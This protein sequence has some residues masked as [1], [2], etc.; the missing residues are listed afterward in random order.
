MNLVK[1]RRLHLTVYLDQPLTGVV[2]AFIE[3]A[4]A[5]FGLEPAETMK[6]TLAGEEIFSFL[7]GLAR[8]DETLEIGCLGRG[9]QVELDFLLGRRRFNMKSFNLT[10]RVSLESEAEWE[11]IGLL[12]ASRLTDGL[13]LIEDENKGFKL[14]LIKEK[15]Y[16]EASP[17]ELP[18]WDPDQGHKLQA[19]G[20]ET[21]KYFLSLLSS[22]PSPAGY[23]PFFRFPGRAADMAAQGELKALLALDQRK[24][25]GGGIVWRGLGFRTIEFFGP[26][27]FYPES[28]PGLAEE[29]VQGLLGQVARSEAV[30]LINRYATPALPAGYFES[31][32]Q[33]SRFEGQSPY[34]RPAFYRLL[35]EDLGCAVWAAPE[36]ESFLKREYSRLVLPRDIRLL[37][38][39]GE[40]VPDESALST[41]FHRESGEAIL[42]PLQPGRDSYRNLTGHV[43]LLRQEGLNNIFFE[44]DLS[45]AWP[46]GFTAG[47]IAAGFSPRIVI[48][49]GGESDLVVFQ[50]LPEARPA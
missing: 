15:T 32:G 36:L 23:P 7:C 28:R 49:Y 46:V 38:D 6:L 26:Y 19:A 16:P 29:L 2:S 35:R 4:A 25:L 48:P 8:P 12:L 37:A 5:A 33:I 13:K 41:E 17:T 27:V 1:T 22:Q 9:Y 42:R 18:P 39:L 44:M 24:N 14:S 45:Q 34:S 43:H 20:P 11:E 21:I 50:H 30:G 31:L 40:Q 47:L 3:K 10:A